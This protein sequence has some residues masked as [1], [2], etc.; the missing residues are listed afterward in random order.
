MQGRKIAKGAGVQT[1]RLDEMNEAA[2]RLNLD[3]ET[4]PGKS[5]P[6]SWWEKHGYLVIDKK[7]TKNEVL[8]NVATEIR[9][10][11]AAKT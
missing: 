3:V 9:R 8:R 7:K 10:I 6:R 5:R 11:R 2:K 1:P 4:H